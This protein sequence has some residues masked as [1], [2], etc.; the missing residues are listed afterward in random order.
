MPITIEEAREMLAQLGLA[1]PNFILLSILGI[2]NK[3]IPCMVGGGYDA[4]TQRL[5]LS[6][7]IALL[8]ISQGARRVKSQTAPSGASQ[9]F[10]YGTLVEQ[11]RGIR[12][13]LSM[14]DPNNCAGAVIPVDQAAPIALYSVGSPCE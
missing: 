2:V 4:D 14:L 7:A 12:A 3:I 5:V 10:E 8:A 6:Y 1:L 13:A 11:G 9:S